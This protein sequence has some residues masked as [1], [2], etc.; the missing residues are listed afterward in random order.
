MTQDDPPLTLARLA[1]QYGLKT[2]DADRAAEKLGLKLRRGAA[3]VMPWQE[4]K[5]RPE[6][7][8]MKAEKDYR[9][10]RAAQDAADDYREH[11]ANK[12]TARLGFTNTEMA[13]QL[14][15]ILKRMQDETGSG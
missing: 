12:E 3:K 4:E 1:G 6:L 8:R 10:Y 14:A 9:S 13:R 2:L 11:L 15:P 7:A 5:L